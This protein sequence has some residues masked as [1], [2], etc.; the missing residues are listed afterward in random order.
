VPELTRIVAEPFTPI[1]VGKDDRREVLLKLL[2][3]HLRAGAVDSLGAIGAAAASAARPVFF[4]AL[5]VRV[6]PSVV[7][8]PDDALYIHLVGLVVLE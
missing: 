2:N 6:L 5:P 1:R 8:T 7:R 3:I 4:G